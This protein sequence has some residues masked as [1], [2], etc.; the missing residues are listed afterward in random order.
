METAFALCQLAGCWALPTVGTGGGCTA[1]GG[2]SEPVAP[3]VLLFWRATPPRP[4]GPSP[5]AVTWSLQFP[6][7]R[8]ASFG[9]PPGRSQDQRRPRGPRAPSAVRLSSNNPS[10]FSLLPQPWGAGCLELAVC[11]GAH[12][13]ASGGVFSC[14]N[15]GEA[16]GVLLASG[17]E[18]TGR[19]LTILQCTGCTHTR[20]HTEAHT[21]AHA[22]TEACTPCMHAQAHTGKCMHI[23]VHTQAHAHMRTH[24]AQNCQQCPSGETALESSFWG[25][26][27]WPS[28]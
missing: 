23:H 8:R 18:R 2:K 10:F 3:P 24:T 28:G 26:T 5:A 9:R 14:H 27:P 21:H 4:Q 15:S 22:H 11:P 13:A 16:R 17:E 1:R 20:T 19:L 25:L 12:V 7:S 6:S